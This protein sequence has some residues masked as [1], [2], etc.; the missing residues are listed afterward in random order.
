MSNIL[1]AHDI[2]IVMYSI[3]HADDIIV[4]YIYDNEATEETIFGYLHNRHREDGLPIQK[5]NL[6]SII[7]E[8]ENM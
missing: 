5:I 7:R 6:I 8:A 1:K 2:V 3:E 4:D